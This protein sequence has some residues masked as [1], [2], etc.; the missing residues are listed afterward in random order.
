M[1]SDDEQ[2][3]LAGFLAGYTG[4]THDAYSLDLRQYTSWC[5]LHGLRLFAAR[6]VDIE[7]FRGE[8]ELQDTR[9]T[10]ARRQLHRRRVLPLGRR[11]RA[12]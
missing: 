7:T 10:I 1:F 11:G 5:T 8:M 12:A 4:L 6:R 3:A 9:A 2:A